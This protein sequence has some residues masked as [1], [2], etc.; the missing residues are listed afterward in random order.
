MTRAGRTSGASSF[1][2]PAFFSRAAR[3][4]LARRCARWTISSAVSF[5]MSAV[6]PRC[7]TSDRPWV[8]SHCGD[9]GSSQSVAA[10]S[11][12]EGTAPTANIARH[13][14]LAEKARLTR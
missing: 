5:P 11:S 7:A 6:M 10:T 9:S 14:S 4:S 2:R 13:C 12:A 1:L 8:M 3:S